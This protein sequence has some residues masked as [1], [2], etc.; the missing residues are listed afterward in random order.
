MIV[1]A[2]PLVTCDRKLDTSGHRARV[3]IMAGSH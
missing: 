2:P 1:F 3:E